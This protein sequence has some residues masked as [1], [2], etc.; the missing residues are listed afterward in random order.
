MT[1]S[2]PIA[3]PDSSTLMIIL[4]IF[5][6]IAMIL[7][8]TLFFLVWKVNQQKKQLRN[9]TE[10]EVEEFIMGKPDYIPFQ[11]DMS[12]YAYYLP[13]DKSFEIAKEDLE[14]GMGW[15]LSPVICSKTILI[16]LQIMTE[17]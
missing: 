17:Y 1:Y 4:G 13:Y 2:F 3:D 6:I 8:P 15:N 9:L 14:I 7:V 5:G 12:T 11:S 16:F 10:E